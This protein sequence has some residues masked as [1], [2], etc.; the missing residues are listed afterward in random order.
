M[1]RKRMVNNI[2]SSKDIKNSKANG[3]KGN[4]KKKNLSLSWKSQKYTVNYS[5]YL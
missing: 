5:P 4:E 1:V 3:H 2:L